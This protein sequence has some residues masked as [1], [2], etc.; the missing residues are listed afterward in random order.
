[1]KPQPFLKLR[2]KSRPAQKPARFC[3]SAGH[4]QAPIIHSTTQA[5]GKAAAGTLGRGRRN[6]AHAH[7]L[8][9]TAPSPAAPSLNHP[10]PLA[11]EEVGG[12]PKTPGSQAHPGPG[13]AVQPPGGLH[14]LAH[15]QPGRSGCVQHH[16]VLEK[17]AQVRD[18]ALQGCRRLRQLGPPQ[19]PKPPSKTSPPPPRGA[20]PAASADA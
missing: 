17:G 3:S 4:P 16:Q 15:L 11:G 2:C 10:R 19:D 12:G 1:M 7:S 9:A 14:P 8:A 13:A 5:V 6:A 18:H 20:A